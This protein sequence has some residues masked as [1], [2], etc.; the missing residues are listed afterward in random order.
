M[1]T[2]VEVFK[3]LLRLLFQLC[4]CSDLCL[5]LL[6]CFIIIAIVIIIITLHYIFLYSTVMNNCC[7]I[8]YLND[9]I[10]LYN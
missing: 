6:L 3:L 9:Y 4:T 5:F 2:Q 10:I 7:G 1:S 8:C